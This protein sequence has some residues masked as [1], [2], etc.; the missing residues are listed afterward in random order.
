MAEP[1]QS[2]ARML[3]AAAHQDQLAAQLLSANAAMG[4]GVVGFHAQQAVEKAL[5]AVL[6]ANMIEFRRTHDLLVL[7]DLLEDHGIAPPPDAVWLDE[8]NPYAVEARYGALAPA[9]LDRPHAL[10]AVASTL[11]WAEQM[12]AAQEGNVG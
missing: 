1:L 12:L 5:K 11:A 2:V 10:L 9:G 4:D 8:L 6:S 7:L 3:L